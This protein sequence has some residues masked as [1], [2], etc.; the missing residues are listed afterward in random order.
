MAK[1]KAHCRLFKA[2]NIF[3]LLFNFTL[4]IERA[5]LIDVYIISLCV[6]H[7]PPTARP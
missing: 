6:H 7:Q 2:F 4:P 5:F 1:S 3:G